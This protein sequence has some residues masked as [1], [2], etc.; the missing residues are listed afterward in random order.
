MPLPWPG[1]RPKA[2]S[3]GQ[4]RPGLWS[5]WTIFV[6]WTIW[7]Q[8]AVAMSSA[9]IAELRKETVAMFYHGYDNYMNV[10]FPEDE[11]CHTVRI[12]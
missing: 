9:R 8:T 4:K 6:I 10:A 2:A 3:T 11:V 7:L 1:G 12:I 5:K